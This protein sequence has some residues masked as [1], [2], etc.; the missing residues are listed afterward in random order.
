MQTDANGGKVGG[1][2]QALV[3]KLDP[4]RAVTAAENVG[5]VYTG[6][7]GTLEVRGWNYNINAGARGPGGSLSRQTSQPAEPRQRAGGQSRHAR[8][9]HQRPAKLGYVSCRPGNIERWWPFFADRPWLSGAFDWTGFDYR[10]EPTPYRLALHQLEPR[11]F[12]HVRLSEGQL[13]LFPILVDE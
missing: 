1:S 13:L 8:H 3:K 6:L 5:D 4:T 12:G 10:G 9:L 2:M 7:E 11:D